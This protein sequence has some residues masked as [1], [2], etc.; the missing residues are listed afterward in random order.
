MRDSP[1]KN[2]SSNL[3]SNRLTKEGDKNKRT[4]HQKPP[5]KHLL[6]S[7]MLDQIPVQIIQPAFPPAP[8][9]DC[10]VPGTSYPCRYSSPNCLLNPGYAKKL[11]IRFVS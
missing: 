2:L 1:A 5:H 3:Q 11:T 4:H 9:A 6:E 7:I 10:H 8:R